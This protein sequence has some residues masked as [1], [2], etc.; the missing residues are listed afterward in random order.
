MT[1]SFSA[2][3]VRD[4][5]RRRASPWRQAEPAPWSAR[6]RW[7]VPEGT[8]LNINFPMF[9]KG[10]GDALRIRFTQIGTFIPADGHGKYA[11][12]GWYVKFYEELK[13]DPWYGRQFKKGQAGIGYDLDP[14]WS[15]VHSQD[16]EGWQSKS[17]VDKN[18][19]VTKPGYVTISVID[20]D[21]NAE[22]KIQK[23]VNKRLEGL[24]KK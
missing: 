9:D 11:K 8:G 19:N 3:F 13:N 12:T 14:E 4:G 21:W 23:Q 5:P 24:T 20:G 18:G 15:I 22:R 7:N 2:P 6:P 1:L 10:Q 16:S 17:Q